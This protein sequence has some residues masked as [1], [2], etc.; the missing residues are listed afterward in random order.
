M[1]GDLTEVKNHIAD[2]S[3]LIIYSNNDG[4]VV[5]STEKGEWIRIHDINGRII[6]ELYMQAGMK[7]EIPVKTGVY[8]VNGKTVLVK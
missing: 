5:E 6:K 7:V 1:A 8:V 2:N 4:I 3:S